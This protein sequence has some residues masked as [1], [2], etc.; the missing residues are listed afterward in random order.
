MEVERQSDRYQNG[1]EACYGKTGD[2]HRYRD[3]DVNG[4]SGSGVKGYGLGSVGYGLFTGLASALVVEVILDGPLR[5]L[6]K[7]LP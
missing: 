5:A 3:A 6:P 7:E 4:G 2:V 1:S